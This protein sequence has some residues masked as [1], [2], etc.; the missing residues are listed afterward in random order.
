MALAS[1]VMH[2]RFAYLILVIWFVTDIGIL[3]NYSNAP[4]AHLEYLTSW[5]H[6]A[7]ILSRIGLVIHLYYD[8]GRYEFMVFFFYASGVLLWSGRLAAKEIRN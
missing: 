3:R 8:E 2:K 4:L 6:L 5:S 7:S 1:V